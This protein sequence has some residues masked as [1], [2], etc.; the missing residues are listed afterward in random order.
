MTT[1]T[2]GPAPSW[3][4]IHDGASVMMLAPMEGVTSTPHSVFEAATASD[5]VAYAKALG[6]AVPEELGG[7]FAAPIEQLDA[8]PLPSLTPT[9]PPAYDPITHGVRAATPVKV[10]NDWHQAWEVYPLPAEEVAANQAVAVQAAR[11]QAK[12]NRQAAVDAIQVT[13]QAGNT[14]DGDET[15]QTRMA[16][17]I[18][19]LQATGTP[20]VT[21]VLADNT[22]IQATGA[23]LSEAL[24]LAGAAQAAVWVLE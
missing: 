16:R 22:V 2:I 4:L 11:E 5:C 1:T 13:T 19:A 21:W 10:G 17:A 20:S 18:I 23:E 3:R 9:E 6:L 12:A 15:S 8:M 14:F 7:L 24:A